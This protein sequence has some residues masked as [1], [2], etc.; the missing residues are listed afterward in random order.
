[1]TDNIFFTEAEKAFRRNLG[2]CIFLDVIGF[3]GWLACS[4][5][6]VAFMK[7]DDITRIYWILTITGEVLIMTPIILVQILKYRKCL[8]ELREI[9]EQEMEM[10]ASQ[11]EYRYE[12]YVLSGEYIFF[13]LAYRLLRL[14]DINEIKPVYCYWLLRPVYHLNT[15]VPMM[16]T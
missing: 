7:D 2:H 10:L 16:M 1:M 13:P 11:A 3:L 8:K 5:F 12:T 14:S 9:P 4:Y 15:A 6:L